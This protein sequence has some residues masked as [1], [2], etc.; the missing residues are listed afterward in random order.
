MAAQEEETARTGTAQGGRVLQT[1]LQQSDCGCL[2]LK[3]PHLKSLSPHLKPSYLKSPLLAG[4]IVS[5][6]YVERPA[7]AYQTST[8]VV[9]CTWAQERGNASSLEP[10][11]RV[12]GLPSVNIYYRL[13][14][15]LS[16]QRYLA[17]LPTCYL[18]LLPIGRL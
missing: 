3:P 2:D 14:H 12:G 17:L 13:F 1:I 16:V 9:R 5:G 18:A 8:A 4:A 15:A 11:F 10:T 6:K 7:G